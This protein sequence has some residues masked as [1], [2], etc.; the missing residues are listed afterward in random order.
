MLNSWSQAP[1]GAAW[2]MSKTIL[3]LF[4]D[5]F[6]HRFDHPAPGTVGSLYSEIALPS[7]PGTS[8]ETAGLVCPPRTTLRP[9][10]KPHGFAVLPPLFYMGG[11][12]ICQGV[13]GNS[14]DPVLRFYL[15]AM[16]PS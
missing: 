9:S 3:F 16:R 4:H 7:G 5:S 11:G 14:F 8:S 1:I 2:F 13:S 15:P 12:G 6:S 10:C